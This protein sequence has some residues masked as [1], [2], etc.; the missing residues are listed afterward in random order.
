[1]AQTFDELE[2]NPFYTSLETKFSEKLKEAQKKLWLIC[3]P[4]H[5]SLKG[6]TITKEF[7]DTHVLKPSPFF[8]SHFVTT[9]INN[10]LSFEI[11]DDTIKTQTGTIKILAE[12]TA[13]NDDY[14]P[15]RILITETPLC[16]SSIKDEL[17]CTKNTKNG[18]RLSLNECS[19]F[20]ASFPECSEVLRMLDKKIQIFNTSYM[21]LPQYLQHAS[22]KLKEMLNWVVKEFSS[23][24]QYRTSEDY[25][26]SEISAALENYIMFHVHDKV[27]PVIKKFCKE[28]DRK[29]F[30]KLVSLYEDHVTADQLGVR[31]SFCCETPSAVVELA[32]LNSRKSPA[33]KLHCFMKTLELLNQDIEQFLLET[34]YPVSN[35]DTPCLTTDDLIPLLVNVIVQARPQYFVSNLYYIQNFCWEN[36]PVDKISFVLVTF[37]AAKE[38]LKSK[39]FES[40]KPSSRKIKKELSL[41]EL[42]EVTVEIQNTRKS[43][44]EAK[45]VHIQSP[46]DHLL[47][48]VTK[49]IE[50]STQDL[51]DWNHMKVSYS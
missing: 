27:F 7:V 30:Q 33:E 49:M 36:S 19:S 2:N 40:L 35:K 4:F 29:L 23:S 25:S 26:K 46:T 8:K 51:R 21:V 20:L 15:Y 50:A 5:K 10:P 24:L 14:K 18:L 32:S 37:Q 17:H 41:E 45:P 1:M 34:C 43:S 3:V 47:E 22:L 38:F 9:D 16:S 28:E 12:E 31:E 39:E 11:E 6:A 13:Y 44:S 48:N 42:M